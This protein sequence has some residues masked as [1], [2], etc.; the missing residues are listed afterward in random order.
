VWKYFIKCYTRIFSKFKRYSKKVLGFRWWR[1]KKKI[2]TTK[3]ERRI[4]SFI[5]KYDRV[6]KYKKKER[7]K[8]YNIKKKINKPK[9][10]RKR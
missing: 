8:N 9:F 7:C 1:W 2:I 5:K 4:K 6:I 3:I 10:L